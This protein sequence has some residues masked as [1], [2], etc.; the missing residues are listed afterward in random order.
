M[1]KVFAGR[2]TASSDQ[3]IVV[4]AIGMRINRMFAV[5]RWLRPTINTSRMWWHMQHARP[6]GY[7]SGYLYVYA[8]GV[9]MQ[10][11]W[12]DFE[13]LEAFARSSDQPHLAAWRQLVTQTKTDATF[14]YWH[15]TYRIGP[16]ESECIYGSMPR[17]GMAKATE[18]QQITRSTESARARIE[19]AVDP[20]H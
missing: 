9:G 17:F 20:S 2:Y 4:F 8:R 7:L 5:H 16:G 6:D 10:Q 14:G 12:S 13:S 11:Y 15:E 1:S 18:H 3:P 19:P